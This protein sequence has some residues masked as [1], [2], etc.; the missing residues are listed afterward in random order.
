MCFAET[1]ENSCTKTRWKLDGQDATLFAEEGSALG[2][3]I[4]KK[5]VCETHQVSVPRTRATQAH[6]RLCSEVLQPGVA[7]FHT[8][9]PSSLPYHSAQK[10]SFGKAATQNCKHMRPMTGTY[11]LLVPFEQGE[12]HH[13]AVCE[14][15]GFHISTRTKVRI[16]DF[17]SPR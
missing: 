9:A 7:T 16:L 8:M 10:K 12:R 11:R 14:G 13:Q 17:K 2:S 4:T 15:V 3:F 1:V 5:R 6:G